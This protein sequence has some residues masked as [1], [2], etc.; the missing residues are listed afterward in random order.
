MVK[1][2]QC[3]AWKPRPGSEIYGNCHRHAPEAGLT[4]DSLSCWPLTEDISFCCE[5]IRKSEE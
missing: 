4:D 5:S 1:C 2:C 3:A